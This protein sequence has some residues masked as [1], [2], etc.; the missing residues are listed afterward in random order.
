M[1]H[2]VTVASNVPSRETDLSSL[3]QVSSLFPKRGFEASPD[4]VGGSKG[5]PPVQVI[6]ELDRCTSKLVKLEPNRTG[7]RIWSVVIH[8]SAPQR[9]QEESRIL[10]TAE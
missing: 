3:L 2:D 10:W 1:L 7:E 5:I 4:L 6:N 8:N 9:R